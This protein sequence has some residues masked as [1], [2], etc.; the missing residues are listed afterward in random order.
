MCLQWCHTTHQLIDNDLP[1]THCVLSKALRPDQRCVSCCHHVAR[2]GKSPMCRLTHMGQPLAGGCCHANVIPDMPDDGMMWLTTD[3]VASSALAH[4]RVTSIAELFDH[5]PTAPGY[6]PTVGG[7]IAVN[8]DQLAR[9]EVFGV[10]APDWDNAFGRTVVWTA[11]AEAIVSGP[12]YSDHVL[13]LI[14]EIAAEQTSGM[15]TPA[16]RAE[17]LAAAHA[18]LPL[19][20]NWAGIVNEAIALLEDTT[21]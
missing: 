4:H 19:P 3:D 16:R 10:P 14:E 13:P 17:L 5:S 20:E 21:L 2:D 8:I 9:P 6:T 7:G 18:L 1:C 12:R 11:A 15:L